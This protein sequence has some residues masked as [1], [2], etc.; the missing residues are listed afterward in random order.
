MPRLSISN[1]AIRLQPID[2][3]VSLFCHRHALVVAIVI[4]FHSFD[5]KK[6]QSKE[7]DVYNVVLL[8]Q[9]L[10]VSML[11]VMS[12]ACLSWCTINI[13]GPRLVLHLCICLSLSS[14]NHPCIW[15]NAT[16]HSSFN[17]VVFAQSRC[18]IS[19][20]LIL[21]LVLDFHIPTRSK[22]TF[23]VILKQSTK[24]S[25]SSERSHLLPS[26]ILIQ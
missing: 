14:S 20:F 3:V 22:D 26:I 7:C 21:Q 13:H 10:W 2:V 25:S 16:C 18:A 11:T 1:V 17:S 9:A 5:E 12:M 6:K 23:Q 24:F 19:F 4:L 15:Q 8:L